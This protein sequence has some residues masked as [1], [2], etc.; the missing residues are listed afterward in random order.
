MKKIL[1]I[2][3]NPDMRENTAEILELSNYKVI[4]A[5][6][7]KTGVKLAQDEK[8]DLIICDVMMPELDGYG[9]LHILSKNP[10]TA[11]I[12]FIFLTAKAEKSDLRKGMNLGADDYLTKPF[13]DTE[14]LDA[15]QIRLAKSDILKA[16][17]AKNF[18]GLKDFIRDA[19]GMKELEEMALE[20]NKRQYRKKDIIYNEG[21]T[22]RGLFY[23]ISGKVKT[24]KSNEDA[25]DY[26]TGM[27]AAGEFLGYA[28]LLEENK[29]TENAMAWEDAQLVQIPKE[30]F[31]NLLHK[32]RDVAS[33]F[34]KMLSNDLKEQEERLLKLAYNSVRKR[35][36]DSLMMLY[37]KYKHEDARRFSMAIP[38]EDLASIVG[39]AT[40]SVIRVLS[41]FK[42]EGLLEIKG[43]QITVLDP[44]KLSRMRN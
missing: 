41:D 44:E 2:E 9:V 11:S 3:D 36:A 28:A 10:A 30:D 15:V 18:E 14:L 25:K 26:I 7:G 17:Y 27:H 21:D 20:K 5:E 19:G 34:I 23:I 37:K 35:V 31:F 16:E 13:D 43:S 38:R 12:P 24:Y 22:P 39:T 6:H 4:T 29:Y 40:E 33:R 8:P 42:N 32:S 1:L